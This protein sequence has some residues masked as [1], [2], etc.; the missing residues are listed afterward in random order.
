MQILA[1]ILS[2]TGGAFELVGLAMVIR[3][4]G[5]DRKR[6]AE[7]IAKTRELRTP[8][9]TYP[10]EMP[11]PS[12]RVLP[13]DRASYFDKPDV[14]EARAQMERGFAMLGNALIRMKKKTDEER[15]DLEVR[16]LEEIDRGDDELR[17]SF[18]EKRRLSEAPSVFELGQTPDRRHQSYVP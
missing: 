5:S 18:R 17:Q 3:Q 12:G 14:Y 11:V 6:A 16:M 7:L 9:R 13:G 8:R 1:V 15:D 2:A 10:S 4:I